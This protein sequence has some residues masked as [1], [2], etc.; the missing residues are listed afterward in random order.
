L[1][2]A[3]YRRRSAAS[4][5]STMGTGVSSSLRERTVGGLHDFILGEV[6]TRV[7]ARGRRALD[8]GAGSGALA[9]R[10]R[11]LG[12]EILAVDVDREQFKPDVPFLPMDLEAQDLAACLGKGS[13]DL[14]TAIEIIEHLEN[15]IAFLRSVRSLLRPEGLA[16]VTTPNMENAPNR[17]KFLLTGKLHMM[18]EC[19]PCHISPIFHDLFVREYVRRAGLVVRGYLAFPPDGYKQVRHAW[20]LSLLGRLLP[21]DAVP[22]DVHVFVL[23]PASS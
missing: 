15:P 14:V 8:L 23:S 18:D 9:V 13:F 17:V 7:S 19:V 22:G 21:G 20:A 10:L 3:W 5:G 4:Y 1:S 2:F 11:Q 16:V 12:F 6:L